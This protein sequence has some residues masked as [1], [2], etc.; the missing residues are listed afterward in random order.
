MDT[1]RVIKIGGK[2]AEDDQKL[3][4][5]LNEFQSM[6][7]TKILVHGGGVIA[8]T[9]GKK[10]GIKPKMI[11]GR[12][13]TDRET[14]DVTTMVYA[15]LINKKI[16]AKLQALGQNAIGLT[17]ADLNVVASVKRNPVP[18]NFGWVGDIEQVKTDWLKAFVEQGI[19][20]VLAPL[21]HDGKGSMLNTNADSIAAYVA[22]ELAMRYRVQLV[23]FFD[24]CGVLKD[25]E[26]IP[27]IAFDEFEQLKVEGVVTDGMIPKLELSFHALL[28]GVEKVFIRGF[29]D[30]NDDTKGTVLTL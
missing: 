12:R 7:G 13:V 26:V 23:Y 6:K 15:G 11:D 25:G 10:L 1:I 27:R 19:V 28:K 18:I 9:I 20:P 2:L 5:F 8:S 3:M 30:V 21:T 16:V 29:S 17:G 22:A 14:L 4:A 24:Y